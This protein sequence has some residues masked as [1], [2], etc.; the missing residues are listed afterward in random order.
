MFESAEGVR[1][2]ILDK[3]RKE[4]E[5]A[6]FTSSIHVA[7]SMAGGTGSGLGCAI[8]ESVKNV[9]GH[10]TLLQNTV[11][12][13]F[14][15]GEVI[16]Q[17]YNASLTLSKLQ[18]SSDA[19]LTFENDTVA[20]ACKKLYNIA[21]PRMSDLNDVIGDSIASALLP[22]YTSKSQEDA[23]VSPSTLADIISHMA[24][25]PGFKFINAK[26]VPMIPEKSVEFTRET[27]EGGIVGRLR[28]MHKCG[29][30]LDNEIK[31]DVKAD[32][33][34]S[35][36][37]L[38]ILRGDSGLPPCFSSKPSPPNFFADPSFHSLPPPSPP[39]AA[40]GRH[41]HSHSQPLKKYPSDDVWK[42]CCD[43]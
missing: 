7:H 20:R 11:V 43:R 17:D 37:N 23:K 31:W 10:K 40:D 21:R 35:V 8:T 39:P 41:I 28:Q 14:Q 6:D 15:S 13:P 2:T 9:F 16:V 22:S 38:L 29:A 42:T 3:I 24:P 5:R 25:H 32:L 12:A 30:D 26:M 36:A 19:I 27:W 34:K 18:E 33:F 1:S 4:L